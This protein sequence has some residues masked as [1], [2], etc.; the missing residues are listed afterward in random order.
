MS[1]TLNRN[2]PR[3]LWKQLLLN[4][5]PALSLLTDNSDYTVKGYKIDETEAQR[6]ERMRTGAVDMMPNQ[7]FDVGLFFAGGGFGRL[8][9]SS[10]GIHTTQ[11]TAFQ[12]TTPEALAAREAVENGATLFRGGTLGRSAGPEGQFWAL[13]HPLS[14]GFAQRYGVPP[15]NMPFDFIEY[16][17]LKP[18]ARFVTT[19][20][21]GVG[22]NRG[23]AINAVAEENGL[24]LMASVSL[25]I[26]T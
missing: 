6:K 4:G 15:E 14:P 13:E 20:A 3:P 8:N 26:T 11:G 9:R 2:G 17:K 5:D 18:G 22:P 10:T 12:A 24:G 25:K 19:P 23:G 21:P 7:A 16:G 1:L